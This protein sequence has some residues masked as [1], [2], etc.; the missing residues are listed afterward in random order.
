VDS[1]YTDWAR[2]NVPDNTCGLHNQIGTVRFY[3]R[4]NVNLTGWHPG[5]TTVGDSAQYGRVCPTTPRSLRS[6]GDDLRAPFWNDP[7]VAEADSQIRSESSRFL[8]V[9]WNC[10]G[11]KKWVDPDY[12]P[13]NT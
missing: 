5:G 4:E 2:A 8:F 7:P 9:K 12:G 11:P 13:K 3:C 10:C 1:T 6:T